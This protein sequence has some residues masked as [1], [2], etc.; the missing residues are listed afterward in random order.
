LI[1]GEGLGHTPDSAA[2]ISTKIRR[3]F[4][5]VDAVLLVD[6]AASVMQAAPT[7]AL[8]TI[9]AAGYASKLIYCFTHFDALRRLDN[10]PDRASKEH[11]IIASVESVLRAIGQDLGPFH[12]RI[13]HRRLENASVF[14]GGIDERLDP[15]R[16][17]DKNT[18]EQMLHL[19]VTIDNVINRPEPVAVRPMYDR[20]NVILAVRAA[21]EG[22]QRRWRALLGVEA[23]PGI[24]KEHWSRIKALTRRFAEGSQELKPVADLVKLLQERVARVV[25]NPVGWQG[26]EPS[27]EEKQQVFDLFKQQITTQ[28]DMLASQ[29]VRTERLADWANAYRLR[30]TGATF[31]RADLLADDVYGRAAPVPEDV[32]SLD[33][34]HFLHEV[35]AAVDVAAAAAGVVF[36]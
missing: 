5:S 26:A 29:R 12:E 7:E 10:L 17:V 3:H 18:V 20:M 21:A 11:H 36:R 4:Q 2:A 6:S 35:V 15:K 9:A 13:L 22:Y 30:G 33:R 27:D 31:R 1:D 25:E 32:P 28:I 16:K 8:K 14:V 23:R 34:N 19:L 24:T